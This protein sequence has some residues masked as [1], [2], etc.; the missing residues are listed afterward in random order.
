MKSLSIQN[1]GF[2]GSKITTVVPTFSDDFTS[3][4]DQ[5]AGD[6]VWVTTDT[7][8]LRVNPTTD[9]L[10]FSIVRDTTA[11]RIYYDLTSINDTAWILRFKMILNTVTNSAVDPAIGA[12]GLCSSNNIH[13]GANDFIGLTIRTN[14]GSTVFKTTDTDNDDPVGGTADATFSTVVTTGTYYV[15][16]KRTLATS[17][18]ITLFSNSVYSTT[19]E[20]QT[21]ATLS[22]TNNLRYFTIG[23]LSSSTQT[24]TVVGTIDDI[25]F[26]NGVTSV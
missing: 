9:V 19:I 26:Y 10:D 6:A 14:S 18:T 11:D 12:F 16:I 20:T 7:A 21:S 24:G 2:L 22:T 23:N 13:D 1:A 5:T 4:A 3:Y 25:K 17:Y 8:R 15:E